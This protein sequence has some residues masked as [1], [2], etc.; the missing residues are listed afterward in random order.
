MSNGIQADLGF[1][2]TTPNPLDTRKKVETIAERD[3]LVTNFQAYESLRTYVVETKTWYE[4][5]GTEWV[6]AGA[7]ADVDS[8]TETEWNTYFDT[9]EITANTTTGGGI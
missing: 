2:L 4:Y 1:E 3:A 8:M 6:I 9:L 7:S 5:N